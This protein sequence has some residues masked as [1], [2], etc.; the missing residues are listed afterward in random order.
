QAGRAAMSSTAAAPAGAV[1]L[2]ATIRAF[3][4][5]GAQSTLVLP[6]LSPDERKQAKRLVDGH[7]GLR[8]ESYGLGADR[9]LHVFRDAAPRASSGVAAAPLLP[10]RCVSREFGDA[11]CGDAAEAQGVSRARQ[12]AG[13]AMLK[14]GLSSPYDRGC[15]E[16][17]EACSICLDGLV[18]PARLPCGHRFCVH[19]VLPLFGHPPE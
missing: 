16:C 1:D 12:A 7:P 9:Q 6:N 13:D 19:C 5:D 15:E 17:S 8:C 3:L 14:L 4:A 10:A 11:D 18:D 2:D